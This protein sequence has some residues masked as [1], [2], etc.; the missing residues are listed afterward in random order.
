[1]HYST[2]IEDRLALMS[3][4][5]IEKEIA[6]TLAS[7]KAELA[8]KYSANT[9]GGSW[10]TFTPDPVSGLPPAEYFRDYGPRQS[11]SD[12]TNIEQMQRWVAKLARARAIQLERRDKAERDA[13]LHVKYE[14]DAAR[15]TLADLPRAVQ[16]F[17]AFAVKQRTAFDFLNEIAQAIRLLGGSTRTHRSYDHLVQTSADA[18]RTLGQSAPVTPDIDFARE[19]EIMEVIGLISHGFQHG[20]GL[21]ATH[22]TEKGEAR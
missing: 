16:N 5:E 19:E 15:Q 12:Q 11:R 9:P 21:H 6:A 22:P 14:R 1:M 4:K 10:H 7:I 3:D 2:P 20:Q 13:A 18:A 8:R 17:E